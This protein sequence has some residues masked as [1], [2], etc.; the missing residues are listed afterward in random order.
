MD[1]VWITF[2]NHV[3]VGAAERDRRP[4]HYEEPPKPPVYITATRLGIVCTLTQQSGSNLIAITSQSHRTH[5]ASCLHP[6]SN[7]ETI[8]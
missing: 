8:V 7:H 4:S 3:A 5:A 2:S 1:M 6:H